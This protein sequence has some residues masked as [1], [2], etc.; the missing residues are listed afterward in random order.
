MKQTNL[1]KTTI[2]RETDLIRYLDIFP[3]TYD[4]TGRLNCLYVEITGP[5]KDYLNVR[6]KQNLVS[7]PIYIAKYTLWKEEMKC[8][9]NDFLPMDLCNLI[10]Q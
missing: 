10:V 5:E 1:K 6:N 8:I 7:V 2:I 9:Y 4:R 3:K